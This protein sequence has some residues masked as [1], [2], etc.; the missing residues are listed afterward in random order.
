MKRKTK[1]TCNSN[2]ILKIMVNVFIFVQ[3]QETFKICVNDKIYFTKLPKNSKID[4]EIVRY[5]IMP[6][7]RE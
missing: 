3:N 4:R 1:K 2:N 5:I 6:D 7:W